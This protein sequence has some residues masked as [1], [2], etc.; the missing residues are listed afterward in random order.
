M[1][2]V[3]VVLLLFSLLLPQL[4][5]PFRS[6]VA[7]VCMATFHQLLGIF[8][9]EL[10]PFRL[11]IWAV[12]AAYYRTLIPFDT[13]PFQCGIEVVQGFIGIALPVGVLYAED[14]LTPL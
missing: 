14:K 4:L 3:A 11:D 8:S 6:T 1:A 13:K 2:V 5:K 9:I 7:V 10:G 12:R